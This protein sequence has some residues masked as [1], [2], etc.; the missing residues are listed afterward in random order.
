MDQISPDPY[1]EE[2]T[3]VSDSQRF[4]QILLKLDN[5]EKL[6]LQR[7]DNLEGLFL[8]KLDNLEELFHVQ[9]PAVINKSISQRV[10]LESD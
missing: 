2:P 10:T 5:L 8:P 4:E 3:K 1:E 7:I 9:R 6:V